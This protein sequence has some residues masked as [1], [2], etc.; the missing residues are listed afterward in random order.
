[1]VQYKELK[2]YR[3]STKPIFPLQKMNTYYVILKNKNTHSNMIVKEK[4]TNVNNALN[5]AR[6]HNNQKG[7]EDIWIPVSYMNPK[8]YKIY[9]KQVKHFSKQT[10]KFIK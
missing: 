6:Y 4:A 5:L 7:T 9:R 3:Y 10:K 2:G 8:D 1:M